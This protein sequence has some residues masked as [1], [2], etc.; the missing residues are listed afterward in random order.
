VV[1]DAFDG[2]GPAG[3][4]LWRINCLQSRRSMALLILPMIAVAAADVV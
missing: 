4:L 2:R 3:Q 1:L